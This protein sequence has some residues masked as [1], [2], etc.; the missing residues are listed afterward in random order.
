MGGVYFMGDPHLKH[1]GIVKYRDFETVEE[2]D[3]RVLDGIFSVSGK[4][5]TLMLLGDVFFDSACYEIATNICE[6]FAAVHLFLGNHCTE[7]GDREGLI[8]RLFIENDNL[9]LHGILS[10]Y[11]MWITHAP[12]HDTELRGKVINLHGH[13]HSQVIDDPRYLCVSAEMI[14]YTPVS[15]EE[16]RAIVESRGLTR[17]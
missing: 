13:N 2:H 7:N 16:V 6:S 3:E 12:I 1:R 14:N 17:E 15:L 5:H 9:H 8:R 11:N 4:R 10:R